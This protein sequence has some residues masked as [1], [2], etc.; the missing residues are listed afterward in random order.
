M[1]IGFCSSLLLLLLSQATLAQELPTTGVIESR[2][3][4]LELRNGFPTDE[5]VQKIYDD[6]DYQRACQAYLWG[7]PLMA[8]QEWQREH[9]ET[10]GAGNLDYVDYF[11][12]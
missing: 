5:T 6:I 10:F 2:L 12:F 4:K 3:G 8:M 7:L 1:K 9:R 11:T